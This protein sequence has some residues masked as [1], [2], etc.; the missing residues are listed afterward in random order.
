MEISLAAETIFHIKNFPVTNSLV[1][2][3]I[4]SSFWITLV[5]FLKK[6]MRLIPGRLQGILELFFEKALELFYQI[7][8]DRKKSIKFFPWVMSIFL[9]ILISNWLG[10]FPGFGSIGIWQHHHNKDI[11]IPFFRAASSDLNVTLAL[12]LVAVI[13]VHIF[14]IATIGVFKYAKRYINFKSPILFFV[15]IL[16][17]ISEAAKVVSFSFRLF[18]N[19]FAGE[20]LL[21]IMSLLIPFILPLPF[22][23]LE[24]FVGAIQA[25]I[26]AVLTLVFLQ[27]ATSEV[28]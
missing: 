15:G 13:A 22:Y 25:F 4:T 28:H 26:F 19:I 8:G 14:G 11:L 10:L 17:L 20:V 27:I 16:E 2:A 7:T 6:R 23:F 12:A 1:A 3:L 21:L 5:L 24:I 18:G 9:F